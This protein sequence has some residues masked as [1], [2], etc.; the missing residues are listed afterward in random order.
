MPQPFL[1]QTAS[2]IS[3]SAAADFRQDA[4]TKL[5]QTAKRQFIAAVFAGILQDRPPAVASR[6]WKAR[7][8]P[9]PRRLCAAETKT[10]SEGVNPSEVVRQFA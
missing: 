2:G 10:T 3:L 1:M 9:R 5:R 7:S 6:L 8:S 4:L